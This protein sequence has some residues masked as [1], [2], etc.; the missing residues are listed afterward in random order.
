MKLDYYNLDN[1][2]GYHPK[3]GLELPGILYPKRKGSIM[4]KI[5]VY[6]RIK[7][8]KEVIVYQKLLLLVSSIPNQEDKT[9]I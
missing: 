7:G 6:P 2:P 5:V 9:H 3:D 4:P 8:C 1:Y